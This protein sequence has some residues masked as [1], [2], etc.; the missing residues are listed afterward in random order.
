[1]AGRS[2]SRRAPWGVWARNTVAR[3]GVP[4]TTPSVDALERV[5]RRAAPGWPRRGSRRPRR[6]GRRGADVASGRAASWTRTTPAAV[7]AS[8]P[9]ATE[10]WRRAP[11]ATTVAPAVSEPGSRLQLRDPLRRGHDDDLAA[12]GRAAHRLD[13]PV[14]HRT[15]ADGRQRLVDAA[16]AAA[17]TGGDDDGIGEARG[18]RGPPS[19]SVV[20]YCPVARERT[21]AGRRALAGRLSPRRPAGRRP[22]GRRRSGG[23]G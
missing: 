9:A 13:R 6:P 20:P 7:A 17:G 12:R 21:R 18:C 5:R 15:A 4:V 2:S 1:M 23:R 16:H 14:E 22:S 3:S 11:P 10:S 8:T 19:A